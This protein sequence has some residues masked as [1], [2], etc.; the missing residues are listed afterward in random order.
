[1]DSK[2]LNVIETIIKNKIQMTGLKIIC[3]QFIIGYLVWLRSILD[4][5]NVNTFF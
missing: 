1:M 2:A 5:I 3:A 4:A